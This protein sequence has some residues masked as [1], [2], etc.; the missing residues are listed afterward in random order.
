MLKKRL[1]LILEAEELRFVT[2]G[3]IHGHRNG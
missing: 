2:Q 1:P 3:S